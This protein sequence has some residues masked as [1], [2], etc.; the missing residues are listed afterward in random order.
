MIGKNIAR[1]RA[2]DDHQR[3]RS[4][5]GDTPCA[6][7]ARGARAATPPCAGAFWLL[8]LLARRLAP[9]LCP[10]SLRAKQEKAKL[11]ENFY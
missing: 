1:P 11:K 2:R 3:E 8:V 4:E 10:R 6:T 7:S 5:G 9:R